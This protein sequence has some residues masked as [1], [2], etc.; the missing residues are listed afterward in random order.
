M[1]SCRFRHARRKNVKVLKPWLI[2]IIR[3]A[4]AT[5][6]SKTEIATKTAHV[7]DA[8][9]V[10]GLA[11]DI[12]TTF[13]IAN[14]AG[15]IILIAIRRV[16]SPDVGRRHPRSGGDFVHDFRWEVEL[17]SRLVVETLKER[18]LVA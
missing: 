9:S 8:P 14:F 6:Y 16:A 12:P 17:E 10:R 4:V 3:P 7:V 11:S 15:H 2:I 1:V 13:H 18:A 5:G